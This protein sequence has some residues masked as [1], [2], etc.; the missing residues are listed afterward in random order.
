MQTFFCKVVAEGVDETDKNQKLITE[1]EN[2]A[3]E[4]SLQ[5][6]TID[7]FFDEFLESVFVRFKNVSNM[8]S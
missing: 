1:L 7:M 8:C 2:V 6:Q 3:S 4:V 5:K